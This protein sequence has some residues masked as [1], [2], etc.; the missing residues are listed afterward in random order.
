MTDAAKLWAVDP[1]LAAAYL[2]IKALFAAQ[3]HGSHL[4]VAQ[5]FR[6]P[7]VQAAAASAGASPYNGTTSWSMHQS[8]PSKAIDVA[9]IGP[10][11]PD[12][13]GVYIAN[14]GDE[15]YQ[16]IGHTFETMGFVWG[17]RFSRAPDYDHMQ[18]AGHGPR[19]LDEAGRAL[20]AYMAAL[21][22]RGVTT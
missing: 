13:P 11:E 19:S 1:A 4:S 17:G 21:A 5:G 9:V 2:K 8:F 22:A 16:W 6:T 18:A 14:G 10:V 20:E 7:T 3:Y 15:R 12:G